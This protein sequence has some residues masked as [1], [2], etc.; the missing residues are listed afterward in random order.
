MEDEM[1]IGK[2]KE[3][4]KNIPNDAYIYVD[5]GCITSILDVRSSENGDVYIVAD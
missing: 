1:T 2:L 4:I 3:L 5:N